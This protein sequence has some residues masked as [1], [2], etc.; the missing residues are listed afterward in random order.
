MDVAGGSD[1]FRRMSMVLTKYLLA[2]DI[3]KVFCLIPLSGCP[4]PSQQ[5]YARSAELHFWT[6]NLGSF[7]AWIIHS[8]EHTKL[9]MEI[10]KDYLAYGSTMVLSIDWFKAFKEYGSCK[11]YFGR[12]QL[13]FKR[14]KELIGFSKAV[15]ARE[16][17]CKEVLARVFI[18]ASIF[19][20]DVSVGSDTLYPQFN[21]QCSWNIRRGIFIMHGQFGL[22]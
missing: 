2:E 11:R 6:P 12:F 4:V 3:F 5:E 15:L 22:W 18:Q 7:Y 19:L 20:G 9:L 8:G 16:E 10:R 13:I 21:L 17:T 14:I 1:K